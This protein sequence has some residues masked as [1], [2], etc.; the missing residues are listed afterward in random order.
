MNYEL[1]AKQLM[2][3]EGV[4]LSPY[5]DTEGYLTCLV[6]Y[7]V[8]ARGWDF[9]ER[10]LGRKIVAP[11]GLTEKILFTRPEALR[12]LDADIHRIEGVIKGGLMPEYVRLDPIRQ[13][14]VLDMGFNMGR[15]ALNFKKARA[16]LVAGQHSACAR[17][18]Y[19][20]RWSKQ[21]GDG[22]TVEQGGKFG[23]EDRLAQMV[24]TGQEPSDQEWLQF[25]KDVA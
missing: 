14:V 10:V 11:G 3:H 5:V 15:K 19:A 6:G 20:S 7:N 12:V 9:V 24:L 1:M 13:R 2:L 22:K 25:L 21:V 16:A 17:E 18:L 8:D 23:R 4:R